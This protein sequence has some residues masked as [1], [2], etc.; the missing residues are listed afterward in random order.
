M[1][2]EIYS[3]IRDWFEAYLKELFERTTDGDVL[4]N[5][6]LKRDHTLRV[7]KNI[8]GIARAEGLNQE[9]IYT[10]M[11]I[12]LL[13]DIGRFPQYLEYRTFRDADSINHGLLGVEML[14]K[15][16]LL[17]GLP[18]KENDIIITAIKFHN[19][20]SLPGLPEDQLFFLRLI[21]DADKLDIWRVFSEYF[22][23]DPQER[24]SGPVLGLPDTE[25]VSEEIVQCLKERR[26]ASLRDA[27]NL[28]DFRLI[29]L[30]WV[31]DL[32]FRESFK[33]LKENGHLAL[34]GDIQGVSP[35]GSP[36]NQRFFGVEDVREVINNVFEYVDWIY[37]RGVLARGSEALPCALKRLSK[38]G[39]V[40]FIGAGPGD[41]E[42]ITMKGKKL[43]DRAD[44]II[45]AG[46]LVNPLLFKDTKAQVYNSAT[47]TL[48]EIMGIMKDSV[49]K[50]K[51]VV[52]LHTGDP[53][54]YSAI[55][56]QIERL[57][58]LDIE[59]EVIPG[60]SSAMAG[61]AILGQELTIPELSQTVIFTRMEGRTPVPETERLRE[62]ARHKATMVIFLSVGMIE[63][64]K[65]ELLQGYPEDTPVVV[66]EKAT[67][68]EQRVLRGTLKELDSIVKEAGIKKTA[69]IYVGDSLR[70]SSESL[71]RESRL[72]SSDFRHTYRI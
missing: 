41:P 64:V 12:G 70:A 1:D 63:K 6:A 48:D 72:Y 21:R 5:F 54:L 3:K 49:Q 30:S 65:E 71:G 38:K 43:L 16:G 66:I 46:S 25:G 29:Q 34:I 35:V 7:V 58:E 8:E 39:K 13:H 53:S 24:S 18:Q 9:D 47:M 15:S 37:A 28:N 36:K 52:R 20:Y 69:L 42:L 61:A 22:S 59:Y 19:S 10:A 2:I 67:W 57:R 32:N 56:E 68:P 4:E 23:T 14:E 44:V 33:L 45:Y 17:D 31:F 55:S 27:R 11:A 51:T 40:Y 50:G 62:L 26:L 60:V